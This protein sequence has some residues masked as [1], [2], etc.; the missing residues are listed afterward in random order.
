MSSDPTA[1][2]CEPGLPAIGQGEGAC[3]DDP[4]AGEVTRARPIV[5]VTAI[6]LKRHAREALAERL[7]P[8]H[9]VVDIREAGS[10]ADLVLIPPASRYLIGL[11]RGMFPRARLLVTEFTDDAYG[12]DFRGPISAILDSDIDGYFIAPTMEDLARVTRDAGQGAAAALTAGAT[13]GR[14]HPADLLQASR[15][16]LEGGDGPREQGRVTIDLE[17]WAQDLQGDADVLAD[18]AWPLILQL[19][20]QGLD[21][22]VIGHPPGTWS[23]RARRLGV[24]V[25]QQRHRG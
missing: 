17:A 8:G 24:E 13:G 7:G 3:P 4:V 9:I 2:S 25:R 5:V 11:L 10:D 1:A 15:H 20:H 19:K 18:L 12:A 16:A 6:A 14:A 23:V 22:T 21:V